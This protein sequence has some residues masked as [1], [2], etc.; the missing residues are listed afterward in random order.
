MT[1]KGFSLIRRR[2]AARKVHGGRAVNVQYAGDEL[3]E[4]HAQLAPKAALQ[5]GVILRSAEKIAHQLP[6]Y[7]AAPQKLH[8]ARGHRGAE[9]RPAIESPYDARGKFQLR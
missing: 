4:R 3:A 8:H 7:G 5:A 2:P 1:G 6:E 9:E